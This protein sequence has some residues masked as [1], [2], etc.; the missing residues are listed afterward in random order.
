MADAF[1]KCVEYQIV[2]NRHAEQVRVCDLLVTVQTPEKG[3]GQCAPVVKA[4]VVEVARMER[5]LL[6]QSRGF[7][8]AEPVWARGKTQES[9]LRPRADRPLQ[10]GSM[11]PL[12]GKMV[13]LMSLKEAG[14]QHIDIDQIKGFSQ[15]RP[16]SLLSPF[17]K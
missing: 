15:D 6:Q 10:A 17:Q 9:S 2:C 7:A 5:H 3:L 11:E 13:M 1:V 16:Q 8:H 12:R 14:D 4:R